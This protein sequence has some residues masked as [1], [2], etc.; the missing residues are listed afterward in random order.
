MAAGNDQ[1]LG[2]DAG[3]RDD[4]AIRL[5]DDHRRTSRCNPGGTDGAQE[6]GT[7]DREHDQE[8]KEWLVLTQCKG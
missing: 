7:G 4:G 3:H 2:Q 6:F 8:Q 1:W 5:D